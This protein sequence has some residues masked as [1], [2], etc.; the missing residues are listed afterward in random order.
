MLHI[1]F[2]CS[3]L[4]SLHSHCSREFHFIHCIVIQTSQQWDA[5]EDISVPLFSH[6][7]RPICSL[8]LNWSGHLDRDS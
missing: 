5:S 6:D 7:V 8:H 1:T 4:Y 2:Y 3:A